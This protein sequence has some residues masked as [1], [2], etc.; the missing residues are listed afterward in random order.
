[1]TVMPSGISAAN[2]SGASRA[3][4]MLVHHAGSTSGEQHAAQWNPKAQ[5]AEQ[6]QP[7]CACTWIISDNC[8][9]IVTTVLA[10]RM[11]GEFTQ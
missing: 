6:T 7:P 5:C 8:I 3:V 4:M 9:H 11:C 1:M 2:E 10:I